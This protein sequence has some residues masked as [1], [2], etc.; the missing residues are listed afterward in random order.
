MK[1]I[2]LKSTNGQFFVEMLVDIL[3]SPDK[4]GAGVRNSAFTIMEIKSLQDSEVKAGFSL[5]Q[6][7]NSVE[8][9]KTFAVAQN[10]LM[11]IV[12]IDP[13]IATENVNAAVTALN[14]TTTGAMTAGNNGV[15]YHQQVV[16]VGGNGPKT[17]SVSSGAIPAGLALDVKS[18]F[19][20]GVPTA[21]VNPTFEIT[22][23]DAF[24]QTDV[25]GGISI[26][27]AA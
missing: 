4:D 17:H 6:L 20:S 12:D 24:G 3:Q 13:A 16:S 15:A 21:V 26:N 9:L 1:T 18:G 2:I 8:G 7:P 14:I 5:R 10:L 23:V 22:V 27:I 25:Q 11:D 19:I